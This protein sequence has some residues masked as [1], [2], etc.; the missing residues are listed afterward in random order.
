V[1]V[2]EAPQR[3]GTA[4]TA[5][6]SGATNRWAASWI[7]DRR[8]PGDAQRQVI[9]ARR[10]VDLVQV[11]GSAPGRIFAEAHYVLVVNGVEVRRGPGRANPRS[12]RYDTVDVARQLRPGTNVLAV[13]AAIDRSA[14][15]NWT[16]APSLVSELTDGALICEID[17]GLDAPVVT[18]ESW[19]TTTLRGWSLSEP[20]GMI[21]RR[22]LELVD[23]GGIPRDL[24]AATLEAGGPWR[25]ATVRSGRTMGDAAGVRA[26]SYPLGPTQASTLSAPS[27]TLRPLA[28][29]PDG[30][31]TLP[32]IGTGTIVVDLEGPAGALVEIATV[33][34]LGPDGAPR[35]LDEPIG[36]RVTVAPTRTTVESLDMF[37][38]RGAVVRAPE[39]VA[40]HGVALRERTHP[41]T[42]S[43]RFACSDPL[44]DQL[45][46]VGRRTVTLCSAD[47]YVD[48]PTRE[49]RAWIG[50]AVVHGMVDLVTNSDWTLARWNPRLAMLSA[51]PDGMLLPAVGGDGES[52]E[53]VVIPDWALHWVHAVWTLHRYTGDAD[54]TAQLL[55]GVERVLDWFEQFRHPLTGLPTDVSGWVLIDWAWVPTRGASCALTGLLGRALLELAEL[56]DAVGD[57]GRATRARRRHA[58]LAE[59]FELFWDQQHRRYADELVLGERGRTAS[60]HGQAAALVGGFAPA[61]RHARL[62]ELL[63]D[64]SHH[65]HAT[66]S[67]PGG[68]PGMTGEAGLPGAQLMLPG[69]PEPWWDAER[70]IVMAQ[71]FFRY[72]VHDALGV[73]GCDDLVVGML[74]AWEPLLARHPTSFGETFW[75]GSVA[76]G[77]SSTP[78]RDLVTKVLGVTP[79][80]PGYAVAR[81]APALGG[82]AWAEGVVPT[83]RGE[84]RARATPRTIEVDS[85]VPVLVEGRRLEPGRHT[86]ARSGGESPQPPRQAEEVD[87][88]P[89][90]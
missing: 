58:R 49:G 67:V 2:P 89:L 30:L 61:E 50:D 42:G 63:A 54:Q 73:A 53:A 39:G 74:R 88:R 68:D 55:P 24:H 46:A 37:G 5:D 32:D 77:W 1:N 25:P 81:V 90:R 62:V 28:E 33:E 45:Y 75:G 29:G 57:A 51:L 80:E 36:M 69:V 9:A 6:A 72:V 12:R 41:V 79:A 19:L 35:P 15:R 65:V 17:V 21:S 11:P 34:Q 7:W 44:L 38:L 20:T 47:A 26:P 43:A 13:I 14:S 86:V 40:V 82:L 16:P 31:W 18:D 4:V 10:T 8:G 27:T 66:L 48:T 76:H 60:Q 87:R 84:I 83:P 85:P 64:T 22:G 23:A 3:A 70:L 59:G 71:P 78:T 56:A 52:G